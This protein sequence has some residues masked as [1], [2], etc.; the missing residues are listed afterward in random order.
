MSENISILVVDEDAE[1]LRSAVSSLHPEG[2]RAEGALSGKEAM[3]KIKYNH[4]DLVLAC[5]GIHDINGISLIKWIRRFRPVTGI[6]VTAGNA[7]QE[8]VKEALKLGAIDQ[9]IKPFTPEMLKDAVIRAIA[10][11]KGHAAG[12]AREKDSALQMFAEL[13]GMIQEYGKKPRSIIMLL[14]FAQDLFGYLPLLIQERIARGLNMYPSEIRGITSAYSCFKMMPDG[15]RA[16][17]YIKGSERMWRGFIPKTGRKITEAVN[18][19]I[20]RKQ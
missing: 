5:L 3:Q 17:C 15:G 18:E 10:R 13:D 9:L 6:V 19:Y 1:I 14:L 11:I 7:A 4:Y 20:K 2:Y 8:S 16:A 12:N